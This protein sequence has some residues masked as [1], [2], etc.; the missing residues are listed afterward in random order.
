M[1]RTITTSLAVLALGVAAACRARPAEQPD[2]S[3]RAIAFLLDSLGREVGSV[4]FTETPGTPGV[5]YAIQVSR[6][7][8]T[9]QH[10]IHMHSVGACDAMSAFESAGGHFNP[11]NKR[12]G[13]FAADG[14]HAG[15]I[16]AITVDVA[17]QASFTANASR[18]TL[19]PGPNS[20]LDADGSAIVLHALPDDQRTDPGGNSGRRIACGVITRV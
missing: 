5:S 6:G 14:P 12:H 17:G 18:V 16:E 20:L 3:V 4:R 9:G 11:G 19:S 8:T 15:D 10:G 1:N 7:A 2:N 13:L